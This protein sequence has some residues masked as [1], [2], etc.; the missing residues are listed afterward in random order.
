MSEELSNLKPGNLKGA[1]QRGEARLDGASGARQN[2]G[3]AARIDSR[4][5]GRSRSSERSSRWK[6]GLKIKKNS[7]E[8]RRPGKGWSEGGGVRKKKMKKKKRGSSFLRS[9]KW[10]L[11]TFGAKIG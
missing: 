5:E 8:L 2:R 4:V 7:E 10:K 11:S 1:A 3:R 9:R 6:I